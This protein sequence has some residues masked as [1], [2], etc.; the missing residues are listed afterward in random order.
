MEIKRTAITIKELTEGYVNN[1][2]SDIEQGVYAYNGKL[3]VRPA[4]QRMFVY[5]PEQESAVIDTALKGF[6]L[7]IMYWVDN[8][9][10]TYD[11]LD[12]QQRTI[13]LCNF[14]DGKTSC[15]NKWF[16]NNHSMVGEDFRLKIDKLI[17]FDAELYEKFMNYELEIYICKGTKAE[18]MEWFR[19]INI[20]GEKLYPQELRNASYVSKWLTDAKKY[21][22]KASCSSKC[23]AERVGGEYT[24]KNA[25]RQEILEQ[26]ISWITGSSKDE[27]ICQY[28]EEHIG[29]SDAS[30]L[31]NYFNDVINWV[32]EL[33]PG[34]YEKG[35]N[36]VNW[37]IL[38]NQYKNEEFDPDEI[39]EKFN[40][41]IDYKASKELDVS[42]AKICEY[43][44]TR[45]EKLLKHREFNE[46]QK[47]SLY[48][49]QKGICPICGKHFL[50]EEMEAH[51]K[52]PWYKGGLTDVDNGVMICKNCHTNGHAEFAYEL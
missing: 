51:H 37:G 42:V 29:D 15:V 34:T 8:G 46:A 43:C 14:V 6:P 35:M 11:C 52:I 21:F 18:Q 24:N 19:T 10:G 9:D 13:S 26:V 31:W 33:F 3:C 5:K 17:R 4:F 50:K 47:T 30:E 2:E 36:S 12:G 23:P 32:K 22:S 39:C 28:M 20:A 49:K 44:I 27:D 41:L 48:N 40:E 1:S 25:N 38:Y 7:N 45:D 16:N